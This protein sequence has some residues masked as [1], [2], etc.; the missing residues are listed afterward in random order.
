MPPYVK[1]P[2]FAQAEIDW[3]K[4]TFA[5]LEPAL[6]LGRNVADIVSRLEGLSVEP[7]GFLENPEHAF[8]A[9]IERLNHDLRAFLLLLSTGHVAQG[10]AAHAS[11]LEVSH[12][13]VHLLGAPSRPQHW[14]KWRET[15]FAP[16]AAAKVITSSTGMLGW[17]KER[18]DEERTR[19]SWA[20]MFKHHNPLTSQIF[21]RSLGSNAGLALMT[22]VNAM[23][24]VLACLR[25]YVAAR[26]SG[27]T[28]S[29]LLELIAAATN[30][31]EKLMRSIKRTV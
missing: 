27:A 23:D 20:S 12:T 26:L 3:Y 28:A 7:K 31:C 2:R 16:W 30:D 10:A 5:E 24:S 6:S 13:L 25:F 19:Y 4:A 18:R 1:N 29:A 22:L 15:E 21:R 14:V 9:T 8:T 11:L 17:T